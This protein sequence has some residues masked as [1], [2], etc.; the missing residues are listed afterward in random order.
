MRAGLGGTGNKHR[1]PGP[2]DGGGLDLPL[3]GLAFALLTVLAG[4]A[5]KLTQKVRS[6]SVEPAV[7]RVPT[8]RSCEFLTASV[9]SEV[10]FDRARGRPMFHNH[11]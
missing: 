11:Y 6:I 5:H 9:R 7:E 10:D 4:E 8:A 1:R 2:V 3:T